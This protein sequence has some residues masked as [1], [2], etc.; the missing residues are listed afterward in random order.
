MKYMGDYHDHYLKK[1][2]LFLGDLLEKLS[3]ELLNF[4]KLGLSHYFWYS[5]LS[6][7]A[8][9][10]TI[11]AKL[12]LISGIDKYLFIEQGLKGVISYICK[13][14]G[15]ANNKY[16]NNCDPTKEIKFIM[17]LEANNLYEWAMSRY[18]PYSK[19]K[20]VNNC[21][22]FDVNSVSKTSEYGN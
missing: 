14:F 2:V 21:D 4:Y 8:M 10:R 12:E 22:N 7:D 1:D 13:R 15:Y 17:Y 5:R 3:S 16:M 6:W 19:F 9:L 11:S 20:W 18:F